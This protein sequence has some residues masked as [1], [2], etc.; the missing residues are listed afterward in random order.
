MPS[1][2]EDSELLIVELAC[3]VQDVVEYVDKCILLQQSAASVK[4]G[5]KVEQSWRKMRWA[6]EKAGS[7]S[8]SGYLAVRVGYCRLVSVAVTSAAQVFGVF[9]ALGFTDT[10]TDEQSLPDKQFALAEGELDIRSG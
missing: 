7:A 6:L 9:V 4:S 3:F 2:F 8:N 10:K 1:P 5:G